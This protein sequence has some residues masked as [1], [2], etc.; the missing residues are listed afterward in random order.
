MGATKGEPLFRG[1]PLVMKALSPTTEAQDQRGRMRAHLGLASLQAYP[2]PNP[3]SKGLAGYFREEMG[4]SPK[5][6]PGGQV[7]CLGIPLDLG[8]LYSALD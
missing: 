7:P 1:K 2:I 8:A 3:Q 5:A 4:Y 6:Y